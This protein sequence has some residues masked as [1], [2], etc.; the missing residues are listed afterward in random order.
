MYRMTKLPFRN[1]FI[2]N[3]HLI[4]LFPLN[5]ER[6]ECFGPL[7]NEKTIF[8]NCHVLRPNTLQ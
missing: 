2:G 6:L 3:E 4:N 1:S 8:P 5:L 7:S